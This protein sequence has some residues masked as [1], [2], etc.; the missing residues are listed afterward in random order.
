MY[1]FFINIMYVFC[2]NIMYVHC[3]ILYQRKKE[4]VE[5]ELAKKG[6]SQTTKLTAEELSEFY[7]MFLN[8][9]YHKHMVYLRYV[10]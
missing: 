7:K 2:I 5:K 10:Q 6:G 9:E 1:V 3:M 8:E 4:F